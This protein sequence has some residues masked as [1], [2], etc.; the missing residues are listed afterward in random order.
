MFKLSHL[1]GGNG[2]VPSIGGT[3][4]LASALAAVAQA[5][6]VLA[7]ARAVAK[8]AARRAGKGVKNLF[9]DGR[10]VS[11]A[12]A[13]RW[14]DSARSAGFNAGMSQMTDMI[15]RAQGDDPPKVRAEMA[16]RT[17]RDSKAADARSARWNAIMRE[18]GWF[19]A[20]AR[21]DHAEAGRIMVEMHDVLTEH[22][23]HVLPRAT[24]E[25]MEREHGGGRT[26]AAAII[27]A[28][29]RARMS[30]DAAGEVPEPEKGTLA[31]K[32]IRAGMRRRGEIA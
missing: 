16:A 26:K 18:A 20:T 31:E 7:T 32:I 23:A 5:E 4:S 19:D 2:S 17:R 29:K 15:I 9:S 1:Y 11:R 22:D 21:G 30:A 25:R 10:F 27:R 3:P 14:T 12:S 8:S 13:E 28:G 24:I 6:D